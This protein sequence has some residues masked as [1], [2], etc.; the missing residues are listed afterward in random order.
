MGR[1]SLRSR[2]G[3]LPARRAG[4]SAQRHRARGGD[5]TARPAGVVRGK[6]QLRRWAPPS[7]GCMCARC[8]G[9]SC[10]MDSTPIGP[11]RPMRPIPPTYAG[12]TVSMVPRLGKRDR[13][14]YV[15]AKVSD[16]HVIYRAQ[17]QGAS[18]QRRPHRA[19]C[20]RSAREFSSLSSS[21]R[22]PRDRP[23]LRVT[24]EGA[25]WDDPVTEP[26]VEGFLARDAAR[27]MWWSCACR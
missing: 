4:A 18:R 25:S 16:E 23:G 27:A 24:G 17:C 15:L 1:L 2:D 11:R 6:R 14:L 20:G 5:R 22:S 8:P 12:A 10:W 21:R 19:G 13:Y 7:P 26:R 3:A 9:Q